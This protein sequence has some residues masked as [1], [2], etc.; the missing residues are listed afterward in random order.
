MVAVGDFALQGVRRPHC[1]D[2]VPQQP[3]A[4]ASRGGVVVLHIQQG[5]QGISWKL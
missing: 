4:G 1:S 2:G 3:P 5:F